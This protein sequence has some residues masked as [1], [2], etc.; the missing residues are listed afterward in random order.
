MYTYEMHVPAKN[1]TRYLVNNMN[2]KKTNTENYK[3]LFI[4][5]DFNNA[6][7]AES[8]LISRMH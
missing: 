6:I 8:E 4:V 2:F 1:K 3:L 7:D 5:I